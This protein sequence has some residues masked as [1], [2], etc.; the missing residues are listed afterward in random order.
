MCGPRSVVDPRRGRHPTPGP[1]SRIA[2]ARSR[3]PWHRVP[4]ETPQA[5]RT[6]VARWDVTRLEAGRWIGGARLV[7][8]RV[9][10]I[11]GE[12]RRAQT[13]TGGAGDAPGYNPGI[14]RVSALPD[15][16]LDSASPH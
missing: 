12:P 9:R 15:R 11:L 5:R 4:P 14:Q 10:W 2:P 3:T 6:V 8:G 7:L 16:R 1:W 13:T